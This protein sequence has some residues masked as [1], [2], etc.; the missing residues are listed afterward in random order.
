MH[1]KNKIR[2]EVSSGNIFKDLG[3]PNPEVEEMKAQLSIKIFRI[4]ENKKK[5]LTQVQI[6]KLLG[7]DQSEVSKLKQGQY[8]RFSLE[9]LLYFLNRLH[10]NVDIKRSNARGAHAYQRVIGGN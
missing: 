8:F 4:L 1:K 5:K 9:R 10:Y 6:A 2:Y 3:L 7:I